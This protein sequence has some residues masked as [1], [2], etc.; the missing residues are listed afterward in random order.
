MMFVIMCD[1]ILIKRNG[2]V[3]QSSS[4]I[5]HTGLITAADMELRFLSQQ[6]CW[7]IPEPW[8]ESWTGWCQGPQTE[9]IK[10]ISAAH[11][12]NFHRVPSL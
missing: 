4:R 11:K 8:L 1:N 3:T 2:G 6:Q 5:R 7:L 10:Q 12:G 9:P